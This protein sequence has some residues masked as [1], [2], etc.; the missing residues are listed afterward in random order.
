MKFDS[1]KLRELVELKNLPFEQRFLTIDTY[2]DK[3]DPLSKRFGGNFCAESERAFGLGLLK[4]FEIRGIKA[5]GPFVKV[6]KIKEY[7]SGRSYDRDETDSGNMDVTLVYKVSLRGKDIFVACKTSFTF[8]MLLRH[9]VEQDKAKILLYPYIEYVEVWGDDDLKSLMKTFPNADDKYFSSSRVDVDR[10]LFGDA[11]FLLEQLGL[12]TEKE[13]CLMSIDT[14]NYSTRYTI[15]LN[16]LR[17]MNISGMY[18]IRPWLR[19]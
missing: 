6:K 3:S 5:K 19:P 14:G 18:C 7:A 12:C 13:K 8:P 4:D 2:R 16:D 10:K 9:V 15:N 11:L 1:K 17:T